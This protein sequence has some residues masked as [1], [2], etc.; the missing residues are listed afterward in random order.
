[1]IQG[2]TYH[3]AAEEGE[4]GEEGRGPGAVID[5]NFGRAQHYVIRGEGLEGTGLSRQAFTAVHFPVYAQW[6]RIQP[7]AANCHG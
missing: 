7:R 1:M 3:R 2:L 4:L 5:G 6:T